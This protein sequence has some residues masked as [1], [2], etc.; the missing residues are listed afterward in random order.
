[1]KFLCL[2]CGTVRTFLLFT[3]GLELTAGDSPV[4]DAGHTQDI[5]NEIVGI[6]DMMS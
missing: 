3:P 1:M 2:V 4:G 5:I 6:Y